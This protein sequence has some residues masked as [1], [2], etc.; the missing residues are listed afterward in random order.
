MTVGTKGHEVRA[1]FG[2]KE[3]IAIAVSLVLL[4]ITA[5]GVVWSAGRQE[6]RIRELERRSEISEATQQRTIELA[7]Q[8]A[9]R[10][11]RMEGRP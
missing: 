3:W 1:R 10:I 11:A 7:S 6:Q 5:G 8:L 4:A 2:G 9:E